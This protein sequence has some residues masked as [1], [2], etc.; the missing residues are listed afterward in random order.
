MHLTQTQYGLL[1]DLTKS[2]PRVLSVPSSE[3]ADGVV[4]IPERQPDTSN[5]VPSTDLQPEIRTVDESTGSRSWATLDLSVTL[6]VVKLHLYDEFASSEESLKEH[7]ITRLALNSCRFRAKMLSDGASEAELVIKSFTM[8]NTRPGNT[9]FREIIP[10]AQHSRNQVMLLFTSSGGTDKS[11]IAVMTVDSPQVIFAVEPIIG[12][13]EFFTSA[14][15]GDREEPQT[16]EEAESELAA[17]GPTSSAMNFRLD[18]HDVSVSVLENDADANTRAIRLGIRKVLMSQQVS[19]V[20][21]SHLLYSD[22]FGR[23]FWP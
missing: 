9:K 23:V 5:I 18:L 19:S 14:F 2:I 22:A 6:D 7:G 8:S 1:I 16:D 3:V 13:I 17:T 20:H 12:L 21:R 10:A 15:N 4:Y 11:S